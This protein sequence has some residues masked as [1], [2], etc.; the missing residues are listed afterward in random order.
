LRTGE[1]QGNLVIQEL[2]KGERGQSCG[3]LQQRRGNK[4]QRVRKLRGK[5]LRIRPKGRG[6]T[7]SI[8]PEDQETTGK[9]GSKKRGKRVQLGDHPV[10]DK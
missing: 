4:N 7:K 8:Y 5:N 10:H 1:G 9:R 3:N 6:E 2:E